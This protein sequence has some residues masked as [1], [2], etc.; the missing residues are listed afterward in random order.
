MKK[1]FDL[2]F[3]MFIFFLCAG[4]VLVYIAYGIYV[5]TEDLFTFDFEYDEEEG[6]GII[7]MIPILNLLLTLAIG[8]ASLYFSFILSQ[9]VYI[10]LSKVIK[11]KFKF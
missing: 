11:K 2:T 1:I 10:S 6:E 8:S 7:I 5:T 4:L 3:F 9:S